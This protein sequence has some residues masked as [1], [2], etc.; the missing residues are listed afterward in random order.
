MPN[1]TQHLLAPLVSDDREELRGAGFSFTV[2]Y[3][4]LGAFFGL[5]FPLLATG[6]VFFTRALPFNLPGAIEAQR[7]EPLLWIIDTAPFFLGL[8]AAIAGRREDRL[9]YAYAR[10]RSLADSLEQRVAERTQALAA[11]AEVSR[12]LSNILDPQQLVVEVVE[13]VRAAF[14]YYHA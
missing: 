12:R 8:F 1:S 10:L 6:I 13:Q 2:R 9:R 3:A 11:S 4:L 14:N 5:L 7:S